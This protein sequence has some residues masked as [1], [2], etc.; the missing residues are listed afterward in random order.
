M[1]PQYE[2]RVRNNVMANHLQLSGH[3]V[4]IFSASALHNLAINLME[5]T[6]CLF[7][8]REYD[9]LHFVHVRTPNY[10][11]NG[12]GRIFNML[13]F[14]IG[15]Y[16]AATRIE[17]RPNVIICNQSGLFAFLPFV[18]A[19]R[20]KARFVLEVRDLWP[21]SIV[22]YKKISRNNPII[23]LLY[24]LEKWSYKVADRLVL[25]V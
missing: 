13:R 21:E 22:V 4:K 2:V 1:P 19:R 18:V 3:N 12:I 16:W 6:K 23:K 7:Q 10:T 9:G 5:N 15:F 8:A 14:S 11:G 24:C 17:E 25:C 20:L